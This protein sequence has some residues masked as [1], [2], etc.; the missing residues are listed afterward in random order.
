V[1]HPTCGPYRAIQTESESK[2]SIN[3]SSYLELGSG[4]RVLACGPP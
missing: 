2:P 4:A 1:F 3:P